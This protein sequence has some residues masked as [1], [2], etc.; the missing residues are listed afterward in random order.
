MNEATGYYTESVPIHRPDGS[1]WCLEIT[2]PW[3]AVNVSSPPA[4]PA[5][6][7]NDR[8][9]DTQPQRSET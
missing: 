6:T 8:C 7:Q 2:R 1:V 3:P 9:S 4:P 5:L